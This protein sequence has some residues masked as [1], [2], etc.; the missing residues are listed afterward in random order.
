M[1]D[2]EVCSNSFQYRISSYVHLAYEGWSS[3]GT[4]FA[5]GRVISVVEAA[6]CL[7]SPATHSHEEKVV[8]VMSSKSGLVEVDRHVDERLV[9]YRAAAGSGRLH[10][11]DEDGLAAP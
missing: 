8:D 3:R 7:A 11:I 10:S 9:G 6:Q 1:N 5:W 4:C 2:S